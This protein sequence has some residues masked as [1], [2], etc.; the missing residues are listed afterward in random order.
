MLIFLELT[1]DQFVPSVE[2]YPAKPFPLRTSLAQVCGGTPVPELVDEVFAPVLFRR[3]HW[4]V[5]VEYSPMKAYRDP[6]AS[7]S[8]IITPTH[9]PGPTFWTELICARISPSP[10]NG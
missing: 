5:F 4:N 7:V 10:L 1:D 6:T 8:R 2:L 9:E 3:C